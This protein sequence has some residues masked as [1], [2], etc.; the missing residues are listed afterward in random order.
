MP[1]ILKPQD[2]IAEIT[3]HRTLH[4]K[5]FDLGSGKRRLVQ[6]LGRV[7]FRDDAQQLQ[8]I[9]LTPTIDPATGEI[10]ATEVPY[11]FRVHAKGIGLDYQSR[12]DGGNVTVKLDKIGNRSFNRNKSLS[13]TI[14]GNRVVFADVDNGLDI[15][16]QITRFGVRTFRILKGS[17]AAREWAWEVEHD[18]AGET[19]I[20]KDKIAGQ[21]ASERRVDVIASSTQKV[22]AGNG[23]HKF[24]STEIWNGQVEHTDPATR[25]RSWKKESEVAITYP[26]AIDPDITENIGTSDDDGFQNNAS[27]WYPS[28]A[29]VQFGKYVFYKH[30]AW[31]FQSVAVPVGATIDLANIILNAQANDYGGGGGFLYG[32]DTDDAAALSATIKPSTMAKTSAKTTVAESATTGL[33]TYAVTTIVAEIVARGGW[34]SGNDLT[35]FGTA[36]STGYKRTRF[37]D[38]SDGGTDEAQLEIDYTAGG[39]GGGTS[40]NLL[41][42]GVG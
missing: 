3:S 6:K 23:R 28:T 34:A 38:Y 7:H 31:R 37:E 15:V 42:L 19:K 20:R 2:A 14:Q 40:K 36:T 35:I 29:Q 10:V 25:I 27:G 16:F 24:L 11:R 13:P 22:P 32:Y 8:D 17:Q 30:P 26:I 21:D 5:Q 4:S 9:E 39:G 1:I 18:T 12:E 33:R 41:T